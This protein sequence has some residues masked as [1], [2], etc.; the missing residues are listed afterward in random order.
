MKVLQNLKVYVQILIA[1][2]LRVLNILAF[3]TSKSYFINF[4]IPFYNPLNIK[5]S[6][7]LQ[8]HLNN[9]I[10][11][12]PLSLSFHHFLLNGQPLSTTTTINHKHS[13]ANPNPWLTHCH[14]N[15]HPSKNQHHSPKKQK[16][17]KKTTTT[18]TKTKLNL[19]ERS[20]T[21]RGREGGG[22]QSGEQNP[23]T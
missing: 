3:I 5:H 20:F 18:T 6:I 8:L 13:T 16:Q 12:L 21:V 9:I 11:I 4:N 1:F 23:Q 17:K 19:R 14:H 7:F 15:Q 10:F 2:S 22:G